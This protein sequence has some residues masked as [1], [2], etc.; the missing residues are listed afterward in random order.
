MLRDWLSCWPDHR[1]P[2][3][4]QSLSECPGQ[5]LV[6]WY[7][8]CILHVT[9]LNLCV[10]I[11]SLLVDSSMADTEDLSFPQNEDLINY[12]TSSISVPALVRIP[13]SLLV[14]R[15]GEQNNTGKYPLYAPHKLVGGVF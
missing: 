14:E 2:V 15:L 12:T 13:S 6:R 8:V 1:T 5:T 7:N 10:A 3:D 4:P 9:V 11:S